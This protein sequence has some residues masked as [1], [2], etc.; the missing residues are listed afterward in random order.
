MQ[1]TFAIRCLS[2][3][4]N[5]TSLAYESRSGA[6]FTLPDDLHP[7]LVEGKWKKPKISAMNR[8]RLRKEV[9]AA[10]RKLL[11]LL[12]LLRFLGVYG[13]L[14]YQ[15]VQCTVIVDTV[16]CFVVACAMVF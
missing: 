14:L 8:K 4:A 9:L 12:I 7:R 16:M 5:A 13:C 1:K 15:F 11:F 6:N 3:T 10:G 2:S